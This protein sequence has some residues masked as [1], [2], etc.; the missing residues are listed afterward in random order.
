MSYVLAFLG[1]ALLIILHEGGHFAAAKAV[2]MRVERFSL[3]F[4]PMLFRRRIG[5]T[6]YGIG[7]VPLGGYVKITGM[8]SAETFPTAEIAAR[9]YVN[10]PVWKR[11]VV[12]AAGPA[13]N[14]LVA[15]VLAWVF[16]IGSQTHAVTNAQ[17]QTIPTSTVAAVE[18][19]TAAQ[20]LLQVGDQIVSIDGVRG[21]PTR[22]HQQ[23]TTHTCAGGSHVN[24]CRATT[25]AT[26]VV[27]RAGR[28]VTLHIRPRWSTVNH[29][30]LIG[31]GFA[32]KTAPNG[33]LYSAGQSA[34]GL[35]RVTKAT[36]SDI[37][38]I[39]KPRQRRQLHSIVGAYAI[40][41]QDI[42]S[43]WT[44]GVEIMALISLSLAIINLF[45]FLPL[46]GGHI[47]WALDELIRGRKVPLRVMER[48]SFVGIA[49]IAILLVIGLSNDISSITGKGFGQ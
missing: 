28:L 16:F 22:L 10:Q 44:T 4:G 38:Q 1:F 25:P 40:T 12:I 46:D 8:S 32:D 30:M 27:R 14:L 47:F 17:G 43:G 49:L 11:I 18:T 45:P 21:N 9:A 31:F 36:V 34:A 37:V 24:G 42:A 39:F 19:G 3:F 23:I 33:V 7:V 15:F 13:A 48:A 26:I 5:E 29:E 6:E 35:W 20:G 2:G 41:Q